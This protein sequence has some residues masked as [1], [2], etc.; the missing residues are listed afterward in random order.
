VHCRGIVTR[1]AQGK[2]VRITGS[3]T[4]I[5][6][7]KDLESRLRQEAQF[8]TLTA[9]PNRSYAIDLLRRAIARSKRTGVYRF[10]VL[11]LDC[12][13]F[14]VVNDSLGH[15]AGDVLL[16][17]VTQRLNRAVRTG[18]VVARL[19]GD[20][21]VVILEDAHDEPEAV[22]VA[23][24]I[25]QA[26]ALPFL[27]ENRELV[28][29]VSIGIAMGQPDLDGPED[30]L[31]DADVA[32]YRAKARGRARYE[33]FRPDM[34]VRAQRQMALE[35]DLRLAL[36]RG[37]LTV[38]YQPVW[39][40]ESGRIAGFEALARW[41]HPQHGVLQPADFIPIAEETGLILRL[42]E[43]VLREAARTLAAWNAG[44]PPSAHVWMSVNMAA[45]QLVHPSLV[46]TVKQVLLDTDIPPDRLKLEITESMILAD[47]VAAVSALEQLKAL[48]VRLLMDDFG[49]GHASLSYLHRLPIATI[50][51]DRYFV[52]RI[53]VDQ[54]CY[55]IV[56]TIL[57][58]SRSLRMDVVA[59]G[60]ENERQ[61]HLLRDLGC[62]M[63]QGF[64]L[65]HPLVEAEACGALARDRAGLARGSDERA[66]TS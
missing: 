47:A 25:Q 15:H 62:Q 60:V 42:G 59:E 6:A 21:F 54:E 28:V 53:D 45:R 34:R 48:G 9:L 32:M 24:R 3:L 18:D 2:G 49:T 30:Y 58:L 55:E 29:S 61:M 4:D 41:L 10:A 46:A 56:R 33:V 64:L 14:K 13:R 26:L 52:G 39:E 19:G 27:I 44:L 7:R 20:E 50:K 63:V 35:T 43:W 5:S 51:I 36:D 22:T 65:A 37:E 23:E 66:L 1:D 40:L 31:R 8:D 12:D 11:F 57:N 17:G 38:A 16:Q